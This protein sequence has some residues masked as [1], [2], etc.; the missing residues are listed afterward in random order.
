M[1]LNQPSGCRVPRK[2]GRSCRATVTKSELRASR[3][4]DRRP[5]EPAGRSATRPAGAGRRS[6]ARMLAG[7]ASTATR[8]NH[9]LQF[10]PLK[11][12]YSSRRLC[13]RRRRRAGGP[14]IDAAYGSCHQHCRPWPVLTTLEVSSSPTVERDRWVARWNSDSSATRRATD[15]FAPSTAHRRWSSCTNCSR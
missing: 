10:S 6:D 4:P 5:T 13:R 14:Q 1:P 11:F 15:I 8:L 2:S 12:K 7:D 3:L 9:L